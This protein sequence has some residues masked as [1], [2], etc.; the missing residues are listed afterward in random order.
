MTELNRELAQF[1]AGYENAVINLLQIIDRLPNLDVFRIAV[2]EAI[3][4]A[5]QDQNTEEQAQ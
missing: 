1:E 5:T 4:I 2:E 3:E